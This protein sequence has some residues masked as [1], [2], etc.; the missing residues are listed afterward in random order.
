MATGISI[1]GIVGPNGDV[2]HVDHEY[3]TNNPSIPVVDASLSTSG[4]AADAAA[5]GQ[6]IASV[7]GDIPAIDATLSI[8]GAAADA[9]A[10]GDAI[11]ELREDLNAKITNPSE[12]EEGQILTNDGQGGA[13]WSN[14]GTPTDAQVG[15][16]VEAWLEDHPEATTTVED[17]SLT[18]AKLVTGTLGFVTPEMFGAI[19]D[20][21][22]DDTN[23][24]NTM[25]NYAFA[26]NKIALF[27]SETTY[28][29]TSILIKNANQS[30]DFCGC[31]IK[32]LS[33]DVDAVIVVAFETDVL[34]RPNG[35]I[36]NLFVDMNGLAP[37]GILVNGARRRIFDTISVIN[38]CE[39]G[40][41][42]SVQSA[43]GCLFN[44]IR[45]RSQQNNP[46]LG[47][48]GIYINVSD[49]TFNNIDYINFQTGLYVNGFTTG[50]NI[51]GFINSDDIYVNSVFINAQKG[52]LYS[53][54]YPDTQR[55]VFVLPDEG[56]TMLISN[57]TLVFN[58]VLISSALVSQYRPYVIHVK[59]YFSRRLIINGLTVNSPLY[60]IDHIYNT[61]ANFALE[62][63]G[64]RS[65]KQNA[66]YAS[67]TKIGFEG[68][69]VNSHCSFESIKRTNGYP[70]CFVDGYKDIIVT[71][72]N[73]DESSA[74]VRFDIS[75]VIAPK[76][77]YYPAIVKKSNDELINKIIAV[78]KNDSK[79]KVTAMGGL[80]SGDTLYID[81]PTREYIVTQQT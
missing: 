42:I 69:Y 38:P 81:I 70:C 76:P 48:V 59:T 8:N 19:G 47:T 30:I 34:D 2:H 61:N 4:A 26:Y 22:T 37:V 41:G 80:S 14:V 12:G 43:N 74:I 9:K 18:Y 27:A 28:A 32:G 11:N 13:V 20:G 49:N 78:T 73:V 64:M 58:E 31:T 44:N 29:V 65:Y 55:I 35:Y 10:A 33:S 3:L 60:D 17:G 72:A 7:S 24:V 1:K 39:N 36:K 16:A 52:G 45:L 68:D 63:N 56:V 71:D 75:R 66:E 53:N 62:V 57:L 40:K 67:L 21:V 79:I 54:L 46:A 15:E 6:A 77:G 23:A 25:L 50:S 51:H 5:V